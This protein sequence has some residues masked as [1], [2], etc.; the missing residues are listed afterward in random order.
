MR[1][2]STL[3]LAAL[4]AGCGSP[5]PRQITHPYEFPKLQ[6][7]SA[8]VCSEADKVQGS[9]PFAPCV[10]KTIK[11]NIFFNQSRD[12]RTYALVAVTIAEDGTILSRKLIDSSENQKW[13]EAV[14]RALDVT[15]KL[16][17]EGTRSP[18]LNFEI[19]FTM[20]N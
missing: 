16:P 14:L 13:N 17:I 2:V 5:T 19:N 12:P 9:A 7:T 8:G 11:S 6:E 10:I 20:S 18:P 15:R 1:H 4:I 3:A